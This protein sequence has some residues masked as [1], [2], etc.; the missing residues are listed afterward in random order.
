MIYL[1]CDKKLI[2]LD[3]YST[4]LRAIKSYIFNTIYFHK[5]AR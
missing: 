4:D 3:N 2:K 1:Y 5:K